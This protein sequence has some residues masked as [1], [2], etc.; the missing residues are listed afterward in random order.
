MIYKHSFILGWDLVLNMPWTW[1]HLAIQQFGQ[2]L[3]PNPSL[4]FMLAKHFQPL[5]HELT[6][7]TKKNSA[8]AVPIP[9]VDTLNH[10]SLY[11]PLV[12]RLTMAGN[13]HRPIKMVS[14]VP[15]RPLTSRAGWCSWERKSNSSHA[16]W[17]H[18]CIHYPYPSSISIF[19]APV[20]FP[21]FITDI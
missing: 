20:C 17:G 19:T 15:W 5:G 9:C 11:R 13:V 16:R 18:I 6:K 12:F 21:S 8:P 2:L 10:F 14:I 7:G 1:K 3:D 4:T